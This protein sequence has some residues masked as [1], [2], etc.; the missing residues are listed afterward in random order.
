MKKK[1]FWVLFILLTIFNLSAISTFLFN[2]IFVSKASPIDEEKYL[3]CLR[4][5][6]K[7]SETQ[8]C[9]MKECRGCFQ[10]NAL[11]FS[12]EIK[13]CRIELINTLKFNNPDNNKINFLLNR[14]DSLQSSL[15]REI[16]NNLLIHGQILSNEQREKFFSMMTNEFSL[17]NEANR[18]NHKSNQP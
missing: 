15:L 1:I 3:S 6:L 8:F 14:I 7:L 11:C 2:N 9:K 16:V 5:S 18:L 10:R 13:G 17:N 12:Y 4:D